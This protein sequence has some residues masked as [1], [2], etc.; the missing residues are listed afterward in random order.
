MN[1]PTGHS[2]P[3]VSGRQWPG[4][5]YF[6]TTREGGVSEA[7][8]DAFNL[9]TT[10]G[11]DPDRVQLNRLRLRDRLPG[12]PFWLKQV[13][14]NQVADADDPELVRLSRADD[15]RPCADASVTSVPHRVLAILTADCLPVVIA[16][17]RGRCVG[18]AHA[19]W[20]G[21]A[22]GVLENTLSCLQQRVPHDA[23]WQ[24]W[25]G[26][27]IGADH[28]EVGADVFQAFTHTDPDAAAFFQPGAAPGKW[29][30]NLAGLAQ[31]R[32]NKAGV[33]TVEQSGACTFSE[34]QR[35]Y[36]YRR[37]SRTG[38]FVTVAW[39]SP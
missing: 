10:T 18:L 9:G 37:Q 20:R 12:D 39:L 14:G 13:H 35:F 27:G 38:R 29:L 30:A 15:T 23:Q 16:D 6:S 21:L 1:M 8:Y 34:T 32:L 24:A 7:P 26:P 22:A 19:G 4:I 17:T 5:R 2:F 36:S 31:A 3:V 33:H 25:I 11:D 28:F